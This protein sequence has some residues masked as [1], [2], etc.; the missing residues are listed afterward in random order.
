MAKAGCELIDYYI[1]VNNYKSYV[2]IECGR[3]VDIG[4]LQFGQ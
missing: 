2:I 3:D 1:G 4:A